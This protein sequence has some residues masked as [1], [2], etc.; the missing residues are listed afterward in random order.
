MPFI[1]TNFRSHASGFHP[2]ALQRFKK[3][4]TSFGVRRFSGI[5]ITLDASAPSP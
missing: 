4:R 2:F 1:Y 3:R 5:A